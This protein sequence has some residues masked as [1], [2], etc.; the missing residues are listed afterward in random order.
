MRM[1][2]ADLERMAGGD[3]H[4]GPSTRDEP[5]TIYYLKTSTPHIKDISVSGPYK[6][7]RAVYSQ[8]SYNFGSECQPGR[9]M[10][11]ETII[12]GQPIGFEHVESPISGNQNQKRRIQLIRKTNPA[13]AAR[14]PCPV[15][16]VVRAEV[17]T[18]ASGPSAV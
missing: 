18:D 1:T 14:L 3:D 10:L 6:D 15:F 8:A 12:N 16:N 2:F 11:L 7:L 9:D 5:G 17:A 4:A 13:L